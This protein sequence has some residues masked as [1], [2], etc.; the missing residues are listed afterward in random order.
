[1]QGWDLHFT[2]HCRSAPQD[3]LEALR[4]DY[5]IRNKP[6]LSQKSSAWP[7]RTK[8]ASR[9]KALAL[10]GMLYYIVLPITLAAALARAAL[11]WFFSPK[12]VAASGHGSKDAANGHSGSSR[13]TAL[14]SGA[15]APAP[16]HSAA[17][18]HD[19]WNL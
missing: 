9:V 13:G 2:P 3:V 6:P 4:Q 16:W 14:V 15:C 17:A 8:L 7:A 1:M 5:P 12:P 18:A 19:T 10:L 11:A